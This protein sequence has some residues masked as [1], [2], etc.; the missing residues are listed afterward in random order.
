MG[1]KR[2]SDSPRGLEI[3]ILKICIEMLFNRISLLFSFQLGYTFFCC[4]CNIH[5]WILNVN[6]KSFVSSHSATFV[7]S[8]SL[9]DYSTIF[10][11]PLTR[12]YR[13]K[14]RTGT[15]QRRVGSNLGLD[16]VITFPLLN[17]FST[18]KC[19]LNYAYSECYLKISI[20]FIISFE[21]VNRDKPVSTDPTT[22]H[23]IVIKI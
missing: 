17:T 21:N 23:Y 19:H 2:E 14:Q 8:F 12:E 5:L 15:E 4:C 16:P 11:T 1:K 7:L 20:L 22:G 10:P 6:N 13:C 18:D 9:Q 3:R